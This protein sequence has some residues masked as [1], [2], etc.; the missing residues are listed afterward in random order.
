MVFTRRARRANTT[1]HLLSLPDDVLRIIAEFLRVEY[2][3]GTGAR[4]VVHAE[5][6]HPVFRLYMWNCHTAQKP[7]YARL[8]TAKGRRLREERCYHS[9]LPRVLFGSTFPMQLYPPPIAIWQTRESFSLYDVL[10]K[11]PAFVDH[12][13]ALMED[14]EGVDGLTPPSPRGRAK[15][16]H[17]LRWSRVALTD[18]AVA[19]RNDMRPDNLRDFGDRVDDLLVVNVSVEMIASC[20]AEAQSLRWCCKELTRAVPSPWP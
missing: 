20:R 3:Y 12:L 15:H 10:E 6:G 14:M 1:C 16:S 4:V 11:A 18:W 9:N 17:P 5:E 13:F 8:D 7:R 19:W 2:A